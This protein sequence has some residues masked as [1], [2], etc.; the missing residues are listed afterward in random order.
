MN[1]IYRVI[2]NHAT[3]CYQA[4]TENGKAQGKNNKSRAKLRLPTTIFAIGATL[5]GISAPGLAA[6]GSARVGMAVSATPPV[7]AVGLSGGNVTAGSATIHQ[8]G[9]NTIINQTSNKAAIDWNKF[10][11]GANESVRFNQPNASSLTLNR[12]TGTESS[13]IMGNLSANGHVFILN[14]NGVLFGAG[15]QVNVGGLVAST[16]GLTNENF[17]AGNYQF[18]SI[19]SGN[20]NGSVI[21]DGK[22]SVAP[23]ST[24]ALM[25]PLVQNTGTLSAAGGKVLLAGAQ[26]VTLNLQSDG[27][28]VGYTLDIGSAQALVNNGGLIEAGGGHVVLTAKGVD[29]LSHAVVNHSGV[30]EAQTVSNKSGVIE[31]LADMQSGAVNLNGKLD[32]SAPTSGDGGFVETSAAK[33]QL[34]SNA[35]VT[36]HAANGVTGNYLIDPT[37]IIVANSGG[38]MTPGVLASQLQMTNITLQTLPTGTGNGDIFF[39]DP[40]TWNANKLTLQAHRNINI[41]ANLNASGT[42]K[43]ALH[44]GQGTTN[45]A[46]SDYILGN[47]A[48]VNLPAG[49]NFSTKQGSTGGTKNYTVITTLGQA[50]SVSGT[51][52]QGMNLPSNNGAP[53]GIYA[54]GAD[55]DGVATQGW[56]GGEG[57]L[58]IGNSYPFKGQFHG[59]GHS[60][61]NLYINRPASRKIGL[62]GDA[63][64]GNDNVVI[65]DVSILGGMIVGDRD[66]G[67]LLGQGQ[68]VAVLNSNSSANIVA[69]IGT[70]GG[71]VGNMYGGSISGS[72]ASGNVT[73][74][75]NQGRAGG[76]VGNTSG[77]E[78]GLY[79]STLITRSYSSGNVSG[80]DVVG[81]LVGG[82]WGVITQSYATGNVSY[83]GLEA[84]P[85]MG[86]ANAG[87]LA[88]ANGGTIN[89]SYATGTVSGFSF[90][91]GGLLG[92]NYGV[93]SYSYS[94]GNVSGVNN[95]GGLIGKNFSLGNVSASYSSGIGSGTANVSQTIGL[96]EGGGASTSLSPSSMRSQSSFQG[97]DFTNTWRI[98]EGSSYPM[99]RALTQGKI[100][101]SASARNIE[102][103]YDKTAW[104][105]GIIDYTGFTGG[106]TASSLSGT[107]QWGGTAQGAINAGNYSLIPT[108]LYSQ[109]YEVVYTPGTLTIQARPVS[110]S[111]SKTYNANASF[112]SGF[113]VTDGVLAGDLTPTIT[114]TASVSSAN[115]GTYT[116]FANNQLVSNN[117]NYTP[118]PL[119]A[120]SGSLGKISAT[121]NPAALSMLGVSGSRIYDGTLAANWNDNTQ[122]SGV[123]EGDQGK[124]ALTNGAGTLSAKD[125]GTQELVSVGT[126]SLSGSA[127]G[128]Y[129]LGT[130]GSR[131][132]IQPRPVD[133]IVSKTYDGNPQFNSG[134][135]VSNGGVDGDVMPTI[136]GTATVNSASAGSYSAFTT[137]KLYS[138]DPNYTVSTPGQVKATIEK[139][140]LS[141]LGV[142]GSRTYNGTSFAYWNENTQLLGILAV[143]Q[144]KVALISGF[145][146][147]RGKDAGTQD[148]ISIGSLTLGGSAASNYELGIGG[149]SWKIQPRPVDIAASKTY[150]GNTIFD[151]G[152]VV[153][154]NSIQKGDSVPIISGKAMVS[155]SDVG[156]YSTFVGNGLVSSNPNYIPN[157]TNGQFTINPRVVRIDITDGGILTSRGY[158]SVKN[159]EYD[160]TNAATVRYQLVGQLIG[161]DVYASLDSAF[162]QV[163]VG[164]Q[165]PVNITNIKLVGSQSKNYVFSN[166]PLTQSFRDS[167]F[168]D[169][170]P[171][172]LNVAGVGGRYRLGEQQSSVLWE[173]IKCNLLVGDAISGNA[174]KYKEPNG[175]FTIYQGSL[176]SPSANYQIKFQPAHIYIEGVELLNQYGN[177]QIVAIHNFSLGLEKGNFSLIDAGFS[178]S[179]AANIG[180][181][182][183]DV[184]FDFMVDSAATSL[185]N[186]RNNFVDKVSTQLDNLLATNNINLGDFDINVSN[187]NALIDKVNEY[188]SIFEDESRVK[189]IQNLNIGIKDLKENQERLEYLDYADSLF[190]LG[191]KTTDVS[192]RIAQRIFENKSAAAELNTKL[193]QWLLIPGARQDISQLASFLEGTDVG[194]K[195]LLLETVK[196]IAIDK[197]G[198]VDY[199]TISNIKNA[200]FTTI[201]LAKKEESDSSLNS[202][203]KGS[204]SGKDI[205]KIMLQRKIETALIQKGTSASQMAN[206]RRYEIRGDSIRESNP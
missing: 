15:S 29:A 9:S 105:G 36:T 21:N 63:Y 129:V 58:P 161:A 173:C 91:G 34:L 188:A 120:Y 143:D 121:I 115:A 1:H 176:T 80:G 117:P 2:W 48:K 3:A 196:E 69:N 160:S 200:I 110:L 181:A 162:S 56:N 174:N 50:G 138:S 52:L 59:L 67:G 141:M 37:D 205:L 6:N 132:T 171:R 136:F 94:I 157:L 13:A 149:S 151:S 49:S 125:A 108:G 198:V 131:W 62:F 109:K 44:Y 38:N 194:L 184:Y 65:R 144:G 168:G 167:L 28:L 78:V 20:H 206:L 23:G 204:T 191:T 203:L 169:I 170:T 81:G 158:Q 142:S 64:G 119:Y 82:N 122:L 7:N 156:N 22:I 190:K 55:I 51:D 193:T 139:A 57:F 172:I 201:G 27:G 71:L 96:N 130:S 61:S 124:V 83:S 16:L 79:S 43:L 197:D 113:T 35:Q 87:G 186:L 100:N 202:F 4:V 192:S 182:A 60:V 99:L 104:S 8:N 76:L 165:L 177:N 180:T 25:A 140:S 118:K 86:S 70:A 68:S 107:L 155:D 47:G 41:N 111:V 73:N 93:V 19:N 89:N 185:G 127:A 114:G 152:F 12:V 103:V 116:S 31:L 10:S 18:T 101:L 128:N 17:M 106:D 54:L 148:L 42:A 178:A 98:V 159:K 146:T 30:I 88:G 183:Y 85:T 95:I 33:V 77:E 153:S 175:E 166:D 150:D 102:K 195:S 90:N 187:P 74:K 135:I 154:S 39:N 40:L 46:G 5:A 133:I 84:N 189:I 26:G 145:G 14:P 32:A 163:N 45:G 134:F 11:V 66:V 53:S 92:G 75:D 97:W 123:L 164:S 199:E 137:N 24:L 112:D 147:L 72:S 179:T 126:L